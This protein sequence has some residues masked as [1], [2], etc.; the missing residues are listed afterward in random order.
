MRSHRQRAQW[1]GILVLIALALVPAFLHGHDHGPHGAA[2]SAPCAACTT[3][4]QSVMHAAAPTV[5]AAP[6]F[7]VHGVPDAPQTVRVWAERSTPVGRGP[8][9]LSVVAS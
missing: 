1:M 2:T 9:P 6:R 8:P 7:A 5:S 4:H 3:S